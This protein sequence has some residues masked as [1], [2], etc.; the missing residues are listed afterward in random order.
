MSFVAMSIVNKKMTS[1]AISMLAGYFCRRATA[2]DVPELRKLNTQNMPEQYPARFW[3]ANLEQSLH[4]VVFAATNLRKIVGYVGTMTLDTLSPSIVAPDTLPGTRMLYSIAVTPGHRKRGL[5]SALIE[6]LRR[7]M[8]Q[9]LVLHVRADNLSARTL[10]EKVGFR[11]VRT[12]AGYYGGVD[13]H[14]MRLER[15]TR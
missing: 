15:E 12:I 10:Y 7:L 11:L 13:G 2:A 1:V 8:P 4:L 14:E 9:D 6:A 5:A 3:K